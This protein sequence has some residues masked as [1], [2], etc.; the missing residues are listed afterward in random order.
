MLIIQRLNNNI[1]TTDYT[2]E[3]PFVKSTKFGHY[4]E[5]F[6]S[7]FSHIIVVRLEIYT[8][9]PHL[10]YVLTLSASHLN[11]N[12]TITPYKLWTHKCSVWWIIFSNVTFF[13]SSKISPIL[14]KNTW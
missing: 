13:A 3:T 6:L 1:S 5:L 7:G 14:I 2:I 10:M 9:P 11:N 8:N 4:Q 12:I